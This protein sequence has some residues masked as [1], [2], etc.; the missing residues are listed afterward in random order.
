MR[1]VIDG[2]EFFS[3]FD[4][5]NLGSV[6]STGAWLSPMP[7]HVNQTTPECIDPLQRS[8]S[9]SGVLVGAHASIDALECWYPK[10]ASHAVWQAGPAVDNNTVTISRSSVSTVSP[11]RST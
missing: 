4:S 10:G 6:V 3:D 1:E 8:E 9:T 11:T 7:T 2:V 5:A